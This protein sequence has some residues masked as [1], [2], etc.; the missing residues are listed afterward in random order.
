MGNFL[1][2]LVR[3]YRE[4]MLKR[5]LSPCSDFAFIDFDQYNVQYT[6]MG[7]VR[8]NQIAV[9]LRGYDLLNIS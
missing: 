6:A 8:G 5:F 9:P 3:Q 4:G 7:D 2:I 1:E